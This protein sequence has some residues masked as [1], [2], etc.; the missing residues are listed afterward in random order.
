ML[1]EGG[2]E[3][4]RWT[5][6]PFDVVEGGSDGVE[7]SPSYIFARAAKEGRVTNALILIW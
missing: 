7:K 1:L 5:V 6:E 4:N 2:R 3:A